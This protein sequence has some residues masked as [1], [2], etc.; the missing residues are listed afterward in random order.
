MNRML[1]EAFQTVRLC[2]VR[3]ILICLILRNFY[4]AVLSFDKDSHFVVGPDNRTLSIDEIG[5]GAFSQHQACNKGNPVDRFPFSQSPA[6]TFDIFFAET[7]G[8]A[9]GGYGDPS[10]GRETF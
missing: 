9:H 5:Q 10:R 3:A 6:Y 7:I 4:C 2:S 8:Q 1:D